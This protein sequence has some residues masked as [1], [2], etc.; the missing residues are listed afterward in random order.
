[1]SK[2][3]NLFTKAEMKKAEKE[4]QQYIHCIF[5][6]NDLEEISNNGL[7]NEFIT[8]FQCSRTW[9]FSISDSYE[10][11]LNTYLTDKTEN[12]EQ[13]K[14]TAFYGLCPNF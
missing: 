7:M 10:I 1:M 8:I 6:K 3:K 4:I 14:R 5:P 9:L 11:A 13:F 2:T 12:K